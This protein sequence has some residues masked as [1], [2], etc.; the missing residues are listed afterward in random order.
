MLEAAVARLHSVLFELHSLWVSN[1]LSFHSIYDATAQE[2][3]HLAHIA[4]FHSY[5]KAPSALHYAA[6]CGCTEA[7]VALLLRCPLLNANADT[8]GQTPIFWAAQSGLCGTVELLCK[9]GADPTH[10]DAQGRTPVHL[11]AASGFPQTCSFL[12]SSTQ[13][14]AL[15]VCSRYGFTPLHLAAKHGH[16]TVCRMLLAARADACATSVR[17]RT[18]LN[19]AAMEGHTDVVK[20][21]VA[22]TPD[23]HQAVDLEGKRAL[24]Y[25]RERGFTNV[26]SALSASE[27]LLESRRATW[28]SHFDPD[29]RAMLNVS[30][31]DAY[32]EIGKPHLF[33]LEHSSVCIGCHVVDALSLVGRYV[34]EV[35]VSGVGVFTVAFARR[36]EQRTIDDVQFLLPRRRLGDAVWE[37]GSECWFRVVA[38]LVPELAQ[39][40]GLSIG[41][42]ESPWVP[43]V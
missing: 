25:A 14:Y 37:L 41:V 13:G 33:G 20:C 24:D 3:V 28:R 40:A 8:A 12:L 6:G 16:V 39:R 2:A 18:P 26:A 17:G 38:V 9:H 21:L 32:L 15:E 5:D 30:A 7:C 11:A 19:L 10:T 23:G 22:A 31:C 43:S 34:A 4:D 1:R 27:G 42:V 35:Y 36:K 29:C